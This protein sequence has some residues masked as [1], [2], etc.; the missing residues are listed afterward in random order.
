[1]GSTLL[2]RRT[3][4]GPTFTFEDSRFSHAEE[5]LVT[6]G[7]LTGFVAS[8]VHNETPHTLRII[9]FRKATKHEQTNFFRRIQN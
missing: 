7:M 6:L 2:T 5:R 8:I 9:S 3:C 4:S 1:M